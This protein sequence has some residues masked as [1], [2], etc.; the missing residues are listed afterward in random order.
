M[1]FDKYRHYFDIDPD[2]FPTVNEAVI[3]KNPDMWKKYYPHDTFVKLLKDTVSVL[4][5]EQKRSIWV[6]GAYGTGKSH[7]VLTL[8]KLLDASEEETKEYFQKYQLSNDLYNKFQ[9]A[10][11][12]GTILTVHRYGSSNI[13][14]DAN[15]VFAI[16][17]SIE[18]AMKEKGI[19]NKGESALKGSI[20]KWLEDKENHDFFNSIIVNKKSDLFGGDN[21]DDVIEKLNTLSGNALNTLMDKIFKVADERQ[22]KAMLL[23]TSGLV[24]WIKNIIKANDLKAIVFVWDEFTEYFSNNTKN[25]TGFQ[26]I[27]EISATD[28]FYLMIVTHKS[29]GLFDDADKDK[30][31]I[32]DRFVKPTCIIELPENM[33]FQ[34][35]GVAMKK[36]K[37]EEVLK[38]WEITV[39]DLYDITYESRKLVKESADISDEEFKN[40]LPIHPYTALLLKNISSAFDSNQRSMFDF[41]KD[42]RGDEIK[43]FQWFIDNYGPEDD[44]PLL[45]VDMLWD[46]FYKK[47]KEYLSHDIRSILDCYGRAKSQKLRVEQKKVLKAILL[48]QAISQKV[49]DSVELFIPNEKNVNN[50]F[51]GSSFDNGQASRCAESLVREGILYKKPLGDGKFQYSAMINAGDMMEI[52]KFVNEMKKKTTS[53]LINEGEIEDSIELTGALGLRYYLEFVSTT[54]FD[55]KIKILRNDEHKY[56]N[57]IVAV[58][59]LAKDDSESAVINKKIKAALEDGSYNMIFIDATSTTLGR[60][61]FNQYCDCMAQSMYHS[62]K[63]NNL[64]K[65]YDL[66]AKEELK[67]WKNRINKGEFVVYSADMQNGERVPTIEMLYSLLKEIN[68]KKYKYCLESAYEVTDTLYTSIQL[69]LGVECGIT[70]TVKNAYK[71]TNPRTKLE[72]ALSDVWNYDGEYWKDKPNIVISRIKN[73]VEE[74]IND[75]FKNNGGRV[76]IANIYSVLEAAPFGIM[77][78]AFTAFILGFVLKEYVDGSYTWSNGDVNEILS[79]DK[80]KEMVEG[81]IKQHNTPGIR[82]K[83]NYIVEMNDKEKA[84]NKATSIAFDISEKYCT[85]VEQTRGYIRNQMKKYSFP[86]WTL[87]YIIGQEKTKT[88]KAIL[89]KI[90]DYY[91]GIANNQNIGNGSESDSE[92][93]QKI[94]ELCITH[95]DASN[96]LKNLLCKEKCTAGMK[97]YLLQY[98]N[99]DLVRLAKEVDDGGRYINELRDKFDADAANWVW[100]VSTAQSKIDEVILDYKIILE[101]NKFIPKTTSIEETVRAWCDKCNYIRISY[102]A[103]KDYIVDLSE[104]LRIL[105]EMK[106]T[107]TLLD[108]QKEDFYN[109]LVIN[110]NLFKELYHEQ[111]SYFKEICEIYVDDLTDEDIQN[112]YNTIPAGVFIRDKIEYYNIVD[113]KVTEYKKNSKSAELKKLWKDRTKTE[114]PRDWSNKY[115]M[116]ILCMVDMNEIQKARAAFN[117]INKLHPDEKAINDA[118]D[119]LSN[120]TFFDKLDDISSRNKAFIESI[121]KNFDI[122]LTDIDEVKEYLV[123]KISSEPYDWFGSPE[124]DRKLE[125]LA[126]IKYNQSGCE[127]ALE[128]IDN[129]DLSDVKRYLKELIKDDMVVG[130]AIIKDN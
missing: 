4:R 127:K 129:M 14:S 121:I 93:A 115:K 96:D 61:S 70:R 33:A 43:G 110:L 25:L 26:E 40:I 114:S 42:D 128:K 46:F 118:L 95:K 125:Q 112:V 9:G 54:N 49:G 79:T 91:C 117:T 84:F 27:A 109:Q 56:S 39:D 7:A 22:I 52:D 47:G 78:C 11:N 90:I 53:S 1:A 119:Y 55:S 74:T 113:G 75:S 123:N 116:P 12:S 86:I 50:A 66:R 71:S 57:K 36:N 100:N 23:D 60:D 73:A 92:I 65:Q 105:Y 81:I 122:M 89:E 102:F 76:S 31:K 41:I 5:R 24:A 18:K 72:N 68:R 98:S 83:D 21:V 51:E 103:V 32:L 16:Q 59:A 3:K 99:G 111:I 85:S 107:N 17:E 15:L 20:L 35:I 69:K 19:R 37:D 13:H 106:K 97:A 101:S 6:E 30:T 108:S 2:Y 64:S 80:L 88:G 130:M 63:D 10:K 29:A 87:K 94:G 67:K 45:T 62:G 8:K 34:L 48:L 82:Y 28:P 124:V 126:Q 77:P 58:V 44:D 120:A 104:F 38:D